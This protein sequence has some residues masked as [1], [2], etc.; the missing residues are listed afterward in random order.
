MIILSN[1][2]EQT[3]AP[4][5]PITFDTVVMHTGCAECHRAGTGSI[6]MRK[7]GYYVISFKANVSGTAPVSLA[8][9]TGG[10]PLPETVMVTTPA[11]ATSLMNVSCETVYGNCCGDYDRV[12]VVNTSTTDITVGAG[13]CLFVRRVG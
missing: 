5:Q 2:V 10:E 9:E 7:Q 3:V 1:T 6:K 4:G 11:T 12:T 8:V 13:P